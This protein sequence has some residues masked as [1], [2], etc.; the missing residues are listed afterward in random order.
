MTGTNCR[1]SSRK[2]KQETKPQAKKQVSPL[3]ERM[4]RDMELAGYTKGTQQIYIGA[5]VSN[6]SQ[7]QRG[8]HA[9]LACYLQ[10]M[11]ACPIKAP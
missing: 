10:A 2:S 4:I 8:L 9:E 6:R 3:R 1:P 5:V 11:E 7:A